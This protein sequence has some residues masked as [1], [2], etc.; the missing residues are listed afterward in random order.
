MHGGRPFL[1]WTDI[2]PQANPPPNDDCSED[3]FSGCS[4]HSQWF[5]VLRILGFDFLA[6]EAESA[7]IEDHRIDMALLQEQGFSLRTDKQAEGAFDD[8]DLEFVG[9]SYE[10]HF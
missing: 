4:F 10:R 1:L 9:L 8:R 2:S 5:T 7:G 6:G 3:F